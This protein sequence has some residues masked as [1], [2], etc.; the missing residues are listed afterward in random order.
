MVCSLEDQNITGADIVELCPTFD[1]G[2]TGAI[3][4]KLMA[5]IIAMNQK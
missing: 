4:A 2:S 3:A 5:A 1:N